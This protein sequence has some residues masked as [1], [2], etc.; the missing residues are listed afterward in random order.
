MDGILCLPSSSRKCN[1]DITRTHESQC[2]H[3]PH[4]HKHRQGNEVYDYRMA[5]YINHSNYPKQYAERQNN[6]RV[7]HNSPAERDIR[8]WL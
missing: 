3:N 2:F 6:T 4:K 7:Y 8:F 5:V 1:F